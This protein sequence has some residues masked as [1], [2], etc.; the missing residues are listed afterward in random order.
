MKAIQ[1]HLNRWMLVYVVLAIGAGLVI[2][3]PSAAWTQ[4]NQSG[5]STL[6]TLAVFFVIYPMMVNLKIESLLRASR[7][8]K[9]LS[10]AMVYNFVW[11]PLLG[12]VLA[13]SF[14]S[15][16]LIALGFLLVMVVPCSSMAVGYAGLSGANVELATVAVALSFVI[17]VFSVPVWMTLFASHYAV[18][19]PIQEMVTTILTVLIAPMIL[20]Y[21]TRLMLVHWLGEKKFQQFQPFFPSISLLA[22]FGIIFLIFFGKATMIVSKYQVVLLLLVPSTLYVLLSLVLQTWLNRRLGLSY[23]DHMAVA[24]ASS[25]SNNST[26]IAIATM[27]FSPLVAVPAAT[28]PIIQT[29]LMVSYLKLAPR[30]RA[31]YDQRREAVTPATAS[32]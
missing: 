8:A 21:L 5:V 26:A 15:D 3:Y 10:L 23:R 7:N 30:V 29:L 18:P 4:A 20:G 13:K 14:L 1:E 27:A 31:Y 11:T 32:S 24:F 6:T 19:V 28:M 12:F 17:A 2:G 25:S 9:G 16:P 22:M